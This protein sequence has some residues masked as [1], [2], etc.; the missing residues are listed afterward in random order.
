MNDAKGQPMQDY[1]KGTR[2]W[3]KQPDGSWKIIV[4]MFN[5]DLPAPA[6]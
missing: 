1:G 3:R 6:K 4:D 2:L 5:T